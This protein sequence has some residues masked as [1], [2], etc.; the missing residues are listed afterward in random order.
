MTIIGDIYSIEE[1]G[2]IQGWFGSVWAIAGGLGPLLGGFFVSALSWRWVFWF[3][4]PFG[5]AAVVVLMREFKEKR[6]VVSA[7]VKL[8][9]LGLVTMSAAAVA[10]LSFAERRAMPLTLSIAAVSFAVFIWHGR[11]TSDPLIP[12]KFFNDRFIAIGLLVSFFTGALMLGLLSYAPLYIQGVLGGPPAGAGSALTPML[13]AWPIASNIVGRNIR[14]F[15]FRAPVIVGSTVCAI[16]GVAL[17]ILLPT[18]KAAWPIWIASGLFGVGM[19]TSTVAI[20]VALQ[21][22][23]P[24]NQRGVITALSMFTRTMGS[25]LC[26]GALGALLTYKL[27]SMIDPEQVG[28]LLSHEKLGGAASLAPEVAK[29]LAVSFGPLT[30]TLAAIGVAM[31]VAALFYRP[32][33]AAAQ[34]APAQQAPTTGDS[35]QAAAVAR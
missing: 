29:A 17:A 11:R 9:W 20:V 34:Q 25:A 23:V 6:E 4:V 30:W 18:A 7:P 13:V 22:S 28:V 14:K 31:V 35:G 10:I 19:G 15:G 24:W 1:R 26:V 27:S 12:F 32:P 21:S 2:R 33:S 5:L 8:D 16:G 3:N